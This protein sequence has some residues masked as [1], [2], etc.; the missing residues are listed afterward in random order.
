M[1]E[2]NILEVRNLTKHFKA[3]GRQVVHAVDD[4]SLTL[5]KGRTLGLV[6]ESGCGKSSCARTIIRMYDPTSGQIILDGDDI[7]NLSQKQLKPYRKKMQMIFQDPYASLNARMTV[8]DIIAEPLVAHNVVKRK[9][10]SNELVYPMLERVGLTKEHANRY[11]HEFSGGQ[12]QRV[13]IAR[14]LI[15]QPELVICD[16]PISALDVSIQAQVINL[17]KDFQEEKG[18]S[19][20]FIAHDLSMVRYVSDDVGVMYLGQLVEVCEAGEIYKNPLH[21]YTKGLLGSIPI[22][23]PKLAKMKEKS[24]IEGDIPSPIKPPSGCRFHTRCPYAKPACSEAVPQMKDAG[25]GH[26][27]ACHLY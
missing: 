17:L 15:L 14:A 27:V 3:G 21:P 13:G 24:S 12:R 7:T 11:A 18:V 9:D 22:A 5:K 6:G 4:V 23:N 16:E 1:S 19:Y 20:L 2:Q 10:Q 8:R 26:M 25:N